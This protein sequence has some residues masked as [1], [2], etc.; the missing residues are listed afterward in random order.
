M[1]PTLRYFFGQND[2]GHDLDFEDT[3]THK[4]FKNFRKSVFQFNRSCKGREGLNGR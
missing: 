2:I 3:D 1:Q 4:M